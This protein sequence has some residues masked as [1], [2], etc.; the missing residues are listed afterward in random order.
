[1]TLMEGEMGDYQ[2]PPITDTLMAAARNTAVRLR[3]S[4]L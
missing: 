2:L 1:M 3:A 4:P